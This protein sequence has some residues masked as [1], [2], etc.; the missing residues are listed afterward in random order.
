MAATPEENL[1]TIDVLLSLGTDLP[2]QNTDFDENAV[3]VPLAP[4]PQEPTYA[5]QPSIIGT[6]VKIK[7][8][9]TPPKT[10]QTDAKRK[11][12]FVTVKYKLRWKYVNKTRK[13]PCGKCR[14][15]FNSQREVN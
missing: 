2:V 12:T 13:F 15:I 8:K 3:L 4:Q 1:T 11:K 10:A 9:G 7:D 14:M 5:P 6:A